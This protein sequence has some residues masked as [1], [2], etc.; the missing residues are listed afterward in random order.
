[1][2][3]LVVLY[4]IGKYF[5]ELAQDYNR[6]R[7][8]FLGLGIATYYAGTFLGVNFFYLLQYFG[9]I[10][11]SWSNTFD[12]ILLQICSGIILAIVVYL[13]LY[14]NWKKKDVPDSNEIEKIGK[15]SD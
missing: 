13:F 10:D 11:F 6:H 8:L 12:F 5:Y 14:W 4:F 3:I 7:W 2:L 15:N 9:L 1:M